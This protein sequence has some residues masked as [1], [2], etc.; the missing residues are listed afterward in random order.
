MDHFNDYCFIM[1]RLGKQTGVIL[2]DPQGEE[3]IDD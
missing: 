2:F 3:F 1:Q